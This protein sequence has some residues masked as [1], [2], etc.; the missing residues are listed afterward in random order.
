MLD[1]SKRDTGPNQ[2]D[3]GTRVRHATVTLDSVIAWMSALEARQLADL[4]FPEVSR[5]LRALSATYVERRG[6]LGE[7]AAL[8]GAG[9]RAAFALFYGPLHFL[10]MRHVVGALGSPFT[11]VGTILDLGCGTGAS[12]AGWALACAHPPRIVG[13]D[14][15]PW[16]VAEARRTCDDL[17]LHGSFSVGDMTAAGGRGPRVAG[18]RDNQARRH[19]GQRGTGLL[20]A[21]AVNEVTDAAARASLL[22]RALDHAGV[23]GCVIVL[24]PLAGFV[25]PWWNEW[26]RA[27][28][29]AGGREHE[30]RARLALP[31]IVEK[32][33][34]AAGLNHRELKGRTLTL[35]ARAT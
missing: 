5:A 32:L 1:H 29:A 3:H 12:S 19:A 6:R 30:W 34:R 8:S 28:E 7:G 23:G 31:A 14:R 2:L 18:S 16:A 17:G 27:F 20:L 13:M 21:F 35:G 10:L 24:E 4:T 22:A 25:A 26:R 11:K 9:K 33:D 15:H